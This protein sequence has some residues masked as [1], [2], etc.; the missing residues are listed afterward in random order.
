MGRNEK[1]SVRRLTLSALLVTVMLMLGYVE[2]LVPTGL[3]GV[4]LGLS[5]SVLLIAIVWLGIPNAFALMVVKVLLSGLLFSGVSAMIYAFAGGLLSMIVMALLYKSKAFSL[6]PIAMA[7]GAAHNIGQIAMAMLMLETPRL[8]YYMAILMLVGLGM[9]FAT[10]TVATILLKRL[11]RE[12]L[13]EGLRPEPRSAEP[14]LD[15]DAAPADA[16]TAGVPEYEPQTER[17]EGHGTSARH[18]G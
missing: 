5:N 16:Q 6:I 1:K 18:D 11:P 15:P 3:P 17:D 7:G 13:P 9:G 8:V 10:G 4:K 2:S 14:A 12:L